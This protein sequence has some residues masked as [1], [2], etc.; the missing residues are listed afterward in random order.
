MITDA[1]KAEPGV[2]PGVDPRR[3]AAPA[4]D[5]GPTTDSLSEGPCPPQ[6]AP[7]DS[8]VHRVGWTGPA[9]RRTTCPHCWQRFHLGD[10]LWVATHPGLRGD[11]VA[12]DDA[13]RRFLPTNYNVHGDAIDAGGSACHDLACPHCRLPVPRALLEA[14][15]LYFSLVGVPASGKSYLT[16]AMSWRLRDLLP[17]RFVWG[18]Q[19]IDAQGNA[20]LIEHEQTLF[21]RDKPDE[22]VSLDKTQ[23][24][25]SHYEQVRFGDQQISLARPFQFLLTPPRHQAR[26]RPGETETESETRSRVLNFYDNA[27]EHFLPGNDN[28]LTPGTQHVAR[29]NALMFL[30]DPMQDARCRAALQ[31]ASNDP[32]L[33][34]TFG[35]ASRQDAILNEMGRRIR[36]YAHLDATATIK[37]PLIV[38]VSKA[39]AWLELAGLHWGDEPEPVLQQPDGTWAVDTALIERVSSAV[40][41]WLQK[42]TPEFVS[43]AEGMHETVRYLPVSALGGPPESVGREARL[44]VRPAQLAPRW[45]AAPLLYALSKWSRQTLPDEATPQPTEPNGQDE[46]PAAPED[47]D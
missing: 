39:D 20:A 38:L 43:L 46:T 45:V 21:L 47:A 2:S 17:N 36:R 41:G 23:M 40:R 44:M 42:V 18:F 15:Q 26:S 12:G 13:M 25:G 31:P 19:D 9:K 8:A 14:R 5:A 16:A 27:G 4:T 1:A 29:A 7:D 37:Q 22:P 24:H 10:V 11:P 34:D 30:F 35:H 3:Q 32:Q 28:A 6:S 33:G